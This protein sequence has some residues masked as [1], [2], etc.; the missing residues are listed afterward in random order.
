MR[1][2]IV[3]FNG[4]TQAVAVV[5]EEVADLAT[6]SLERQVRVSDNPEEW[7]IEKVAIDPID[8]VMEHCIR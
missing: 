3:R 6:T 8:T 5:N 7:S 2:I 4:T 1:A